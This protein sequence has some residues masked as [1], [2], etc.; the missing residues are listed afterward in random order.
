MSAE[1]GIAAFWAWWSDGG[2]ERTQ[3]FV[4]G[5]VEHDLAAEIA[6]LVAAIHPGLQWELALG[7]RS[8]HTFVV[9]AAGDPALRATARAWLRAAPA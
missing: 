5:E 2:A 1:A 7:E 9:T 8:R 6:P 4:A 3:E